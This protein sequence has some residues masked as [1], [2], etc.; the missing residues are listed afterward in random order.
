MKHRRLLVLLGAGVCA[1]IG[2][3]SEDF[4]SH[5]A[6]VQDA[7]GDGAFTRGWL[8]EIVP[9]EASDIW[10][11]HNIDTNLTW[12]CFRTPRGSASVRTLLAKA[13]AT[14]ATG[15]IASRPPGFFRTRP[16]W[17]ASMAQAEL[18]RYELKEN[19][20]FTLQIGIDVAE[21]RACLH[22]TTGS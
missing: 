14:R 19:D 17:P 9:E 16:W 18:E 10:E 2:P 5:Y 21:A 13:G 12:A 20:R 22:R 1:C 15:P 6:N 3:F 4:E 11:L 8:P 7:Q